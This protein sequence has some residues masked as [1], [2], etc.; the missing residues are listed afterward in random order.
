M[1]VFPGDFLGY[2]EEYIPGYGVYEED[3]KLFAAAAGKAVVEDKTIKVIP[4]KTIP[5]IEKNDVII[6]RVVDTRS[7]FAM[8]EIA[9]KEGS[10]RALR[11]Y[12]RGFLHISNMSDGY[13]KNVEDG[14]RYMDIIRA[15]V[16]DSNL[17]LSIKEREMGVIRAICEKC[18]TP[19]QK[20]KDKLKCPECGNVEKRKVSEYYG[21]GEW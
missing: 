19:L 13:L 9:R 4:V 7:S 16:I 11:H 14:V 5:E 6:G 10:E 21:R 1:M 18:G 15:R 8:V 20:M 12:D 2:A 17:K 3:G